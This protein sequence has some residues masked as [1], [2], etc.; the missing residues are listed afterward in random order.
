MNSLLLPR[1]EYSVRYTRGVAM[2][3]KKGGLPV[4]NARDGETGTGWVRGREDSHDACQNRRRWKYLQGVAGSF[5][6][7][8]VF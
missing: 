6:E 5:H 8:R 3:S 1:A 7:E 4:R 2:L